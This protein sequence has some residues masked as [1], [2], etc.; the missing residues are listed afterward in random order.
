MAGYPGINPGEVLM[1]SRMAAPVRRAIEQAMDSA[2]ITPDLLVQRHKDLLMKQEMRFNPR[3]MK[4]QN[5]KQP[6]TQA[7]K[8][9]L[10]M[11]YKVRGD[12]APE[13]VLTGH[14]DLNQILEQ[15]QSHEQPIVR[16][17]G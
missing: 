17:P 7:V 8:S 16:N 2:G 11:A 3:S 1:E 5:T 9:A 13:K 6:D 4:Y 12:Y 10:D 15:I 14:F